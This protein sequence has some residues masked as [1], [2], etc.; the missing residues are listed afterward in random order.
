LL[1][2]ECKGRTRGRKRSRQTGPV[3]KARHGSHPAKRI[4]EIAYVHQ[5]Q[6]LFRAARHFVV[7]QRQRLVSAWLLATF[8]QVKA[9]F[10]SR[11]CGKINSWKTCSAL[12]LGGS[13][14][15]DLSDI[16]HKR[17]LPRLAR[18]ASR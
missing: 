8:G 10:S 4:L 6:K 12:R 2:A 7:R 1:A 17:S 3:S 13:R 16:L 9:L 14:L 18:H 5:A 15:K 11:H